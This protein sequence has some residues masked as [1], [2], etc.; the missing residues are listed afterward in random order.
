MI[1]KPERIAFGWQLTLL[2]PERENT[3]VWYIC[4]PLEADI[5]DKNAPTTRRWRFISQCS[6]RH[7]PS[8]HP[9]PSYTRRQP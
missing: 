9:L 5:V 8:C 2:Q 4:S 7:R 1:R 3:S 6:D